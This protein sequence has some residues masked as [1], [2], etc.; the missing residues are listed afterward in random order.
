MEVR[1]LNKLYLIGNSH[2]DPVWQ[3][4]WQ[5]GI[6]EVLATFRSVLDRMNEFPDFKYTSACAL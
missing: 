5:D 4:K 6:T 3:W 1:K 2:I